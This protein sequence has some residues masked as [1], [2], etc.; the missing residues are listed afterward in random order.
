MHSVAT[1]CHTLQHTATHCNTL[2]YTAIYTA[3][4]HNTLQHTTTHCNTL[5]HTATHR[6]KHT[7]EVTDRRVSCF[8][9]VS[10]RVF[11]YRN[12]CCSV[13]FYSVSYRFAEFKLIFGGKSLSLM[14]KRASMRLCIY[15]HRCRDGFDRC[16]DIFSFANQSAINVRVCVYF[17]FR[18]SISTP[19]N[20]WSNQCLHL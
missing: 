14:V 4:H 16:R 9:R 6:N 1:H 12:M 17:F 20:K 7:S 11:S 19:V 13:V 5:Q 10:A 18:K 15:I 3:T 2:Q 8:P